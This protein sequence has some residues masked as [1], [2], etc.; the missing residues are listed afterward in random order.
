[1]KIE[2]TAPKNV[3]GKREPAGAVL[4]VGREIPDWQADS[5]RETGGAIEVK[6]KPAKKTKKKAG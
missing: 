1:M 2:L 6:P 3:Y 5:L 4:E